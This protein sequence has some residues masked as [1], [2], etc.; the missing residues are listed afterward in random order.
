MALYYE[1]DVKNGFVYALTFFSVISDDLSSV[2]QKCL[3]LGV[4]RIRFSKIDHC[5]WI[6]CDLSGL[7]AFG[8]PS[9]EN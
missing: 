2:I 1:W 7:L 4:F 5:A 6:Y 8:N 3:K 9:L